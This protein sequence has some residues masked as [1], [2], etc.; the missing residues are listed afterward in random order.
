MDDGYKSNKGFYISTESFTLIENHTLVK[1]LNNKFNLSC[2]V[3]K[4]INGY[5]IYI[6]SISK[7][8]Y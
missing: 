6:F 5:R 8:H 3:H 7:K 2:G 4:Y 1:F